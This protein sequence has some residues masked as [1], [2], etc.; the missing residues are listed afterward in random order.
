MLLMLCNSTLCTGIQ[1]SNPH[2]WWPN[3]ARSYLI[4]I[5]SF[6]DERVGP[7]MNKVC[8]QLLNELQ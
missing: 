4:G 8:T 5:H 1:H 6:E 7:P 2:F 3:F